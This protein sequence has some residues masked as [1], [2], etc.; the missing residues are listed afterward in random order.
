LF[1]HKRIGNQLVLIPILPIQT[2]T[3]EFVTENY[4]QHPGN[5]NQ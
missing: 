1:R 4:L 2:F 5:E 3:Q